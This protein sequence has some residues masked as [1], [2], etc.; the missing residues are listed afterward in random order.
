M[1]DGKSMPINF[2]ED[3]GPVGQWKALHRRIGARALMAH[4]VAAPR[5][6]THRCA[7]SLKMLDG[8]HDAIKD[9]VEEDETLKQ[10]GKSIRAAVRRRR[11][12]MRNYESPRSQRKRLY[13]DPGREVRAK[14]Q[15]KAAKAGG[16]PKDPAKKCEPEGKPHGKESRAVLTVGLLVL[17]FDWSERLG[18][19][20]DLSEAKKFLASEGAGAFWGS[21]ISFYKSGIDDAW[22]RKRD[23][24]HLCAAFATFLDERT[25]AS[26]FDDN[27]WRR[28]SPKEE[29]ELIKSVEDILNYAKYYEAVLQ[30]VRERAHA[31]MK[32][33][34][35]TLPEWLLLKP[36]PEAGIAK[37]SDRF[38]KAFAI[39]LDR[40]NLGQRRI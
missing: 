40:E 1:T 21:Q 28:F 4:L 30:R 35:R 24:A 8:D 19:P 25:I 7:V 36:L 18:H 29:A 39:W 34:L 32:L 31:T 3:L 37:V 2:V 27:P 10:F 9:E 15:R 11:K 16:A 22:K 17:T 23:V 6:G 14:E 26:S 5:L 20:L 38:K 33:D 13:F 12:L